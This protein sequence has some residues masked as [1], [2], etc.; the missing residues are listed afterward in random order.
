MNV[1]NNLN[2]IEKN[3][4]T[5]LTV[6]TFDGVH[7][8]HQKIIHE[9][10]QRAK[11]FG[12]R[13]FVLTFDPHPQKVVGKNTAIKLLTTTSEKIRI[14]ESLNVENLFFINFTLEFS[15]LTSEDFFK[16]I[17]LEKFG[18]AEIIVGFDHK[19][20]KGRDGDENKI[21]EW[22]DEFGFT[23]THID[24]VQIDDKKVSSTAIREMLN[25]GRV[26]EANQFLGRNYSFVGKVVEGDKR[27]RTIGFPTANL[28][29]CDSDKI[30]PANGVYAVQVM[31]GERK[32]FGMMNIGKRP[33]F[34]DT[35]KILTEVN[36]FE[37]DEMIYGENLV[38][39]CI[40]KIRNEVKF[41]SVDELRSQLKLDKI[42]SLNVLVK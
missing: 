11:L 37:F 4:K 24:A 33:T 12:Y 40:E 27:G 15:Q 17:I 22:S 28:E 23:V 31:L 26:A 2:E 39:E 13:S 7:I 6:G 5:I 29:L 16:K 1:V 36:I 3:V 38:I 9:L 35:E 20:G 30:L 34:S 42:K 32:F 18:L 21:R 19:F 8:G 14:L 10:T 41:N 25:Q